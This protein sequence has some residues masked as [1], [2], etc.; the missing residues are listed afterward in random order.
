MV[1]PYVYEALAEMQRDDGQLGDAENSYQQAEHLLE[2]FNFAKGDQ[3]SEGEVLCGHARCLLAAGRIEEAEA[4]Y[5]RAL[6]SSPH[7]HRVLESWAWFLATRPDVEHRNPARALEVLEKPT[8]DVFNPVNE[9]IRGVA[10]YGT[11][12]WK[13]AKEGYLGREAQILNGRLVPGGA[14]HIREGRKHGA[15]FFLAMAL[16]QLGEKDKARERYGMGL[17]WMD[18]YRPRDAELLRFR[19]EATGVLGASAQIELA[20]RCDEKRQFVAAS[21]HFTAAFTAE[22]KLAEDMFQERYRAAG[23]AAQAAGGQGEDAAPVD[24]PACDNRHWTG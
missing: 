8:P 21:D 9:V 20:K 6:K 5:R 16:W 3:G 12:D 14:I 17:A 13:S 15:D 1:L 22:P 7:R 2:A 10:L 4:L 11:G 18:K 24:A 19:A 23:A